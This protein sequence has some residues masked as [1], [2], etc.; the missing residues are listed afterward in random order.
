M[1]ALAVL[2]LAAIPRTMPSLFTEA[3]TFAQLILIILFG[4]SV[5]AWAIMWDR[6]RLYLSLRS[7]GNA[8]RR[9]LAHDGVAACIG[10]LERYQPSVEGSILAEAKRYLAA[11]GAER[12]GWRLVAGEVSTEEV[13]RV[14]VREV[15]ERR[16]VGEISGMERHLVFLSTTA[17]VA[18]FLGLLGTVWGIMHS[19]LS[20]G[21]E[22]AASIE[23]VGP[24]IAEALVT[25]IAGL[26]SAIPALVGYNLLVRQ[27]H[28]KEAVVDLFISRIVEHAVVSRD[29]AGGANA[30]AQARSEASVK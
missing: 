29:E 3:G 7:R 9:A 5:I 6:T 12:N 8:L 16:A 19:F 18:P 30:T 2:P 21:A 15:L 20:M 28:R 4:I 14:K 27:V 26:A 1:S 13:E 24:G 11:R 25:T 22:G 17:S 23:V 10:R